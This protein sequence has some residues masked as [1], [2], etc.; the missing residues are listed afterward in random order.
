MI[1]MIEDTTTTSAATDSVNTAKLKK[2]NKKCCLLCGVLF[3]M[4][5]MIH[6]VL[7]TVGV[8]PVCHQQ[9]S[10][11]SLCTSTG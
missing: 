4:L 1:H 6:H 3:H 10:V 5:P 8:H 7:D 11:L 2:K 9:L